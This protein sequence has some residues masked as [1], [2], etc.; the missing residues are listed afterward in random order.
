MV[1]FAAVA[2]PEQANPYAVIKAS[3]VMIARG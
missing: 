2:L 3:D 1:R